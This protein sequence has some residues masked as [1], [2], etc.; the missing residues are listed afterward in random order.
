MAE[1]MAHEK[2]YVYSVY[3]HCSLHH[4]LVTIRMY[5]RTYVCC[6]TYVCKYV[7]MYVLSSI[8]T[9]VFISVYSIKDVCLLI[10]DG[11]SSKAMVISGSD[12]G[13]VKIWKTSR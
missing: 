9:I 8:I 7:R 3:S 13:A 4:W 11:K 1:I 2:T 6:F 5:V 10:G 12:D